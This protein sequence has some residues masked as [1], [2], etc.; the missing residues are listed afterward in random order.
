MRKLFGFALLALLVAAAAVVH[1]QDYDYEYGYDNYEDDLDTYDDEYGYYEDDDESYYDYYGYYADDFEGYEDYYDDEDYGEYEDCKVVD[2]KVVL[3]NGTASCDLKITGADKKAD[4][5]AAGVDGIYKLTSCMYGKP[6]YKRVNS[7]GEEE[8]VLWFSEGFGDWDLSKGHEPLTES[9][10]LLYGGEAEHAP[11]P[12]YV[13]SWHLL[14]NYM[15]NSNLPE[16][17]YVPIPLT[18][19]C[20]DGKVPKASAIT[21]GKRQPALTNEEIE[22]KYKII[23]EIYG[24]RPEPN[25]TVNFTFVVLL[26]MTGLTIVLAIPYFLLKKKGSKTPLAGFAQILQQ[27]RKKHSGHYN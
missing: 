25:P 26:V 9:E 2:G 20:A 6:L 22:A 23:Y 21:Q 8:R 24:K 14:A 3:S 13:S 5:L 18:V 27:N 19:T 1:A 17:D 4:K 15:S 12:L 7:S 11:V 16:D 10:I